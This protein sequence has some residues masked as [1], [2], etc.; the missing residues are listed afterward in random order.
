MANPSL[1]NGY[2]SIAHEVVEQ[3]DLNNV[4]GNEMRII[5]VLW[6]K[7]W[8]WNQGKRKKDWDWIS[9]SQFQKMTGM[10]RM[11]V[12]KCIK[13]LVGKRL[14][15]KKENSYKFNQNYEEWVVGKKLPPVVK[16]LLPSRQTATKIG[17]Q[18]ATHN[19]NK[20]TN[21]KESNVATSATP[22]RKKKNYQDRTSMSCDEFVEYCR[23]SP[24][25]HIQIIAEWAEAE[26]PNFTK[27]GEWYSFLDRNLRAAKALIPFE[28]SKIESAY[29]LMLK[30]VEKRDLKTGRKTG[31]I[32][33]YTLETVGKYID[34][35]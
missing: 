2:I 5:W 29:H 22:L 23:K 7:T 8:G 24:H 10:K 3:L 30:D 35:V 27:K 19:R 26:K 9:Y 14:L 16:R 25:K 31:F 28:I 13:S 18:T 6:R 4:P 33:K 32:S 34:L 15:L 12:G 17:R 21:T 20:E 1:K 11:S